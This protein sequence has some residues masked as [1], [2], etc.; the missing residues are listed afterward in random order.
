MLLA[1]PK[2]WGAEGLA[3]ASWTYAKWITLEDSSISACEDSSISARSGAGGNS[4]LRLDTVY[5]PAWG[6]LLQHRLALMWSLYAFSVHVAVQVFCSSWPGF[7]VSTA[8]PHA[9]QL[10]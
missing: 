4:C 2:L 7:M 9:V 5:L 8:R 3:W 6:V 10:A 1:S